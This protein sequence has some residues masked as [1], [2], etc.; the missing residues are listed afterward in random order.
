M[1]KLATILL[2]TASSLAWCQQKSQTTNRFLNQEDSVKIL[3]S[4]L[5]YTPL[6]SLMSEFKGDTLYV[7]DKRTANHVTRL[8]RQGKPVSVAKSSL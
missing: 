4:V 8:Q 6:N 7:F 3:Q 2:L 5:A 1:N